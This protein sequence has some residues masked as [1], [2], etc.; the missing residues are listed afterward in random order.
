MASKSEVGHVR[1]VTNFNLLIAA[2]ESYNHGYNPPKIALQLPQLYTIAI[3][4]QDKLA[5]VTIQNTAYTNTVNARKEA[6]KGLQELFSKILKELETVS[7]NPKILAAAREYHKK[8]HG[9]STANEVQNT[10]KIKLSYDQAVYL[11]TGLIALAESEPK[12]LPEETALKVENLQEMLHWLTQQNKAK[13]LAFNAMKNIRI[14]RDLVLYH[15]ET[16][17]LAIAEAVKKHIESVYGIQSTQYKKV[18][19]LRFK[20]PKL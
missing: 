9:I 17:L 14:E 1:N 20:Q 7:T 15:P 3:I 19:K 13:T 4:A 12:Y 16:G 6:F 11:F 8:I 18:H 10:R 2:A 5:S